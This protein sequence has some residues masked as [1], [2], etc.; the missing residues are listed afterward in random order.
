[1]DNRPAIALTRFGLG[2][3]GAE[4]VPADPHAWLRAQLDA[5]D[6]TPTAGKLTTAQGLAIFV[7][8]RDAL[9]A[10]RRAGVADPGKTVENTVQETFRAE[11]ADQ[12]GTALLAPAPFRERL[13]WFWTNHFTV[14][15]RKPETTATIGAYVREAIRPHVT[16]RFGDMLLAVMRH[17]AMLAYLDNETSMGP[18]SLRGRQHGRGLNENLARE[19]LELH[20]VS[21]A[22]GYTQADVTSFAAVLTGW[23]IALHDPPFGFRFRPDLHEPGEKT[24]LG[25]TWPEGEQGGVELLAFLANHP[26]THRHLAQ[27]LARHFVADDP[28]PDQVG[29]LEAVLR[30]TGGDLGAV[31]AALIELPGAWTPFTKLRAPQDYVIC[32]L[33]ALGATPEQVPNL[34]AM[35][36]A[37]GQPPFHAPFPIGWPD[38][39]ADWAAPEAVMQRIDWAHAVAGR[40]AMLDPV[41]V[42]DN[43]LGPLLGA[44][45]LTEIRRAGSRQDALTLMLASP[46]FMRR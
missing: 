39:A 38:R 45:T 7:Q 16:G 6:P 13:V 27:K 22:A 42:A 1:M 25:R 3:H 35:I 9:H 10:A 26:A 14:A 12:L 37:L 34:F 44:D 4:P 18:N 20:T 21:P 19:C 41:I 24:V 2:R 8:H 28:P 32:S 23:S 29:R 5:P 46:E 11:A 30:D 33:R 43:S 17:P 40:A 15:A 31:S 36:S